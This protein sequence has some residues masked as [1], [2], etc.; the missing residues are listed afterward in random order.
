MAGDFVNMETSADTLQDQIDLLGAVGLKNH[1]TLD[2][3]TAQHGG[4]C[5]FLE[6][7]CP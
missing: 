1:S 7:G 5:L 6:E 2:L 4:S 3:L